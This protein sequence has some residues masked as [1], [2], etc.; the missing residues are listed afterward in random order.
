MCIKETEKEMK[1]LLTALLTL[2]MIINLLAMTSC[3]GADG[4]PDGMELVKGGESDGYYFYGPEEWVIANLGDIGCTYASKIDTSSMSFAQSEKPT[5]TIEEYFES[6]KAK[7]PYE[8]EVSVNG[9]SC[10][11]GNADSI[12]TKYVYTYTYKEISFTTMQIFVTHSERFYIFTYT[13][14]NID[15]RDEK[16]YYEY[17]LD[18]VSATIDAF[19]FTA[20]T[21]KENKDPEYVR[22]HE[23]YIL[24]SD[25]TL[26]GFDMY[27]PDSYKVDYS[28]GIVSVS[29][30]EGASISMT[31][32]TYTGVT[33]LDYWQA[34]IDSINAFA[35]GTCKGVRPLD[36]DGIEDVSLPGTNRAKAYEYTYTLDGKDYHVYQVIIIQSGVNGYVFTYTA[37]EQFYEKYLAEATL[38]LKKIEY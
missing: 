32:L 38:V 23:G 24:V 2:V 33:F 20:K 8:I 19:K 26:S 3:S 37:E 12:A 36:K 6:E 13:A 21:E 7:L 10:N 25:K 31:Q 18:K 4:A 14:S 29:N 9:E 30:Q 27:V 1:K 34:R 17:Y 22:D 35:N 11:F 5:T 16:T 15:Y 28:T